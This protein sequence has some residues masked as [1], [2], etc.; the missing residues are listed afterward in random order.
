MMAWGVPVWLAFVA[1]ATGLGLTVSRVAQ[2]V[3]VRA[4]PDL[5]DGTT[6]ATPRGWGLPA[7][8]APALADLCERLGARSVTV[9]AVDA[10]RV[11]LVVVVSEP[12]DL[13][14]VVERA[15]RLIEP[16]DLAR[17]GLDASLVSVIAEMAETPDGF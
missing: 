3:L 1:A 16:D 14:A 7:C 5:V 15:H 8:Q 6:V 4:N 2:L 10:N 9:Q 17:L 11:H 13:L 12:D